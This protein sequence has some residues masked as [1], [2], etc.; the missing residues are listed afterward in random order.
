MFSGKPGIF[1]LGSQGFF[2]W[3]A[4][5]LVFQF[6]C[7]HSLLDLVFQFVCDHSL[8]INRAFFVAVI[9]VSQIPFLESS[10]ESKMKL[11][12]AKVIQDHRVTVKRATK[13]HEYL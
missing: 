7:D 3:E 11:Q 8:F 4:R 6:V 13:P 2:S 9:L 5:D 10:I 1:F 12:T